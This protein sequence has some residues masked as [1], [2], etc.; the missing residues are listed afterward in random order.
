MDTTQ[1]TQ[2]PPCQC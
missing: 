1:H 2:N